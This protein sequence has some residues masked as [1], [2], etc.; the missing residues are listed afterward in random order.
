MR[1]QSSSTPLPK[2]WPR[3]VRSAMLHVIS[4]AQYAAICTRSWAADSSNARMRL[5]TEQDRLRFTSV[6][7]LLSF[8]LGGKIDSHIED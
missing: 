2:S 6:T 8:G 3:R 7:A 5:R 4:L 1:W